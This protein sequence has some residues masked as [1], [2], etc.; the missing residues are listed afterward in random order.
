LQPR[1][2]GI[3]VTLLSFGGCNLSLKSFCFVLEFQKVFPSF[4]V[5]RVDA[6]N[7]PRPSYPLLNRSL[8]MRHLMRQNK[9]IR[10][11]LTLVSRNLLLRKQS[12][13]H[14]TLRRKTTVKRRRGRLPW[15]E[16]WARSAIFAASCHRH[17]RIQSVDCNVQ[18]A[19]WLSSI[20]TQP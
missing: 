4:V 15:V 10:L 13:T 12:E 14:S 5:S 7:N 3:D 18:R 20:F 1:Q 19:T 16:N 9:E 17:I 11:I 8:I 6:T 2:N